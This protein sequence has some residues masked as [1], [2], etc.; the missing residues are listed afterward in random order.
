LKF[1]N[2]IRKFFGHQIAEQIP[3]MVSLGKY[4]RVTKDG[5]TT[6][7]CKTGYR[8]PRASIAI[9]RG[10]EVGE[11]LT[12]AHYDLACNYSP[13]HTEL[14]VPNPEMYVNQ[15]GG[16]SCS[17]AHELSR[18]QRTSDRKFNSYHS[19]PHVALVTRTK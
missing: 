11:T 18:L 19:E 15:K 8:G 4:C 16:G 14:S 6:T 3:A 5:K 1:R 17:L 13:Q 10:M 12:I 7:V 2:I 9:L